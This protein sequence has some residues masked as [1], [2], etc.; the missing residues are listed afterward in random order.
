MI[1]IKGR[2]AKLWSW[3]SGFRMWTTTR[4]TVADAIVRGLDEF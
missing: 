3:E 2:E 4:F 1:K